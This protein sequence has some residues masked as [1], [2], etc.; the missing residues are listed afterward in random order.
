VFDDEDG[1]AGDGFRLVRESR[2]RGRWTELGA[3]DGQLN[4]E[5][6]AGC[7]PRLEPDA[8]AMLLHDRVRDRQ[9][10]TGSLAH[11]LRREKRVEDL[12]LDFVR[13]SRAIVVDFEDD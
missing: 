5:R 6:G 2:M 7:G 10:E 1:S 11:F 12:R 3:R 13:N 8:A 4:I 9:A